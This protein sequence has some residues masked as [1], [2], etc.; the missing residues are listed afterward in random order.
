MYLP[1][2]NELNKNAVQQKIIDQSDE[3][4]QRNVNQT[5]SSAST[6]FKTSNNETISP[7]GNSKKFS[8]NPSTP[9]EESA[10]LGANKKENSL[11]SVGAGGRINHQ[12]IIFKCRRRFSKS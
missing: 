11:T 4:V 1:S 9:Q 12:L 8:L 7:S 10:L 2:L 5:R 3:R 6:S